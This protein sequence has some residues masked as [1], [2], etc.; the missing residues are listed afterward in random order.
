MSA[1]LQPQGAFVNF[2]PSENPSAVVRTQ[3]FRP[4][5]LELSW[6]DLT[7]YFVEHKQG[8]RLFG[9]S[10]YSL[11]P[12]API[13]FMTRLALLH[14]KSAQPNGDESQENLRQ[15]R[16]TTLWM[17]LYA[18]WWP[19]R[20]KPDGIDQKTVDSYGLDKPDMWVS[21]IKKA[22][23]TFNLNKRRFDDLLAWLQ[24]DDFA[25]EDYFRHVAELWTGNSASTEAI[26]DGLVE[27]PKD[28][29]WIFVQVGLTFEFHE[30]VCLYSFLYM[31]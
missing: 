19:L 24:S 22:W 13:F 11:I 3:S 12:T 29:H 10:H 18:Y 15:V 30:K 21:L 26:K 17:Q 6:R 25:R 27:M 23:N 28:L 20:H 14:A 5:V 31:P 16:V 1:E 8:S 2:R 7:P 4:E 9:Y